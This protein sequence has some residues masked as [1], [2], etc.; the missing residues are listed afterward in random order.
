[1]AVGEGEPSW[2]SFDRA[3]PLLRLRPLSVYRPV[4]CSFLGGTAVDIAGKLMLRRGHNADADCATKRTHDSDADET[5]VVLRDQLA[6]GS[7][8]EAI[9][10]E[11]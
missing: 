8:I 10:R 9:D 11:G 6:G 2:L 3:N 1:M 4:G 5:A 7:H